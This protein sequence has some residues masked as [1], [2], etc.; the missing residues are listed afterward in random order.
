MPSATA[1]GD[2]GI[3]FGLAR[4][5]GGIENRR[6]VLAVVVSTGPGSDRALRPVD[7]R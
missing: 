6:N 3:G 4:A 1:S 5:P 2:A 7:R